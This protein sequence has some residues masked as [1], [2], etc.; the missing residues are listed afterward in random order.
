MAADAVEISDNPEEQRYEARTA[1]ELAGF[2]QYL[3][4]PGVI[5]FVH[6]QVEPSFEGRGIGGSLVRTALDE[7]RSAGLRVLPACP[8]FAAWID[9]HPDYQELV[10]SNSSQVSD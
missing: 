3:R 2:A 8:F 4:G 6:T 9:R 10:F 1:G 7:A 5:A